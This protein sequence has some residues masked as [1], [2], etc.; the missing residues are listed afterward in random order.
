MDRFESSENARGAISLRERE[1]RAPHENT[2]A[3][4]L[5]RTKARRL[6]LGPLKDRLGTPQVVGQAQICVRQ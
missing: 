5:R 6:T 4:H 1:K 2:R 3:G